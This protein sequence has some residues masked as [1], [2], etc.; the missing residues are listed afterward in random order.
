MVVLTNGSRQR[1]RTLAPAKGAIFILVFAALLALRAVY[2]PAALAV[3]EYQVKAAFLYNFAKFVEWPSEAFPNEQAP[4]LL[5][6]LGEDPF[7]EDLDQIVKDKTVNGRRIEVKRFKEARN[8]KECQI[9]FVSASEEESLPEILGALRGAR[10][11]SVGET[12]RFTRL[13]GVLNFKIEKKSV[14]FEINVDAAQRAKL[15]ISSKLLRLG[16]IV[17]GE[18]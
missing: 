7:G 11:F 2:P 4:F 5:C 17:Q 1:N 10:T 15:K 12:E 14:R 16:T 3:T 8:L 18:N 6:V 9:L 13:G